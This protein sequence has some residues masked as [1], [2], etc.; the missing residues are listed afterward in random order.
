LLA[1]R[2]SRLIQIG[3]GGD[4]PPV[5]RGFR[6]NVRSTR[7][8]RVDLDQRTTYRFSIILKRL[9]DCLAEMHQSRYDLSSNG[10]RVMS[11]IGRFGPLAAV[12]VAKYVSLEAD[13]ITR[14]VD[15][16][17]KQ[18][19]VLRR[20]DKVD[21]RRVSLSLSSKGK[22]VHDEIEHVRYALEY[23][24]LSVLDDG[25]LAMLYK[26]LDKL[27]PQAREIFTPKDAWKAI[28]EKHRANPQIEHALSKK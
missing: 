1:Y 10:W 20:H 7:W 26:I 17:V 24:F 5:N 22:K 16:L 8:V 28:F 18:G 6:M 13:K 4:T 12:E 15:V 14:T 3:S 19:F 9:I 11:V 27:E 23:E 2:N 25:E 21:R